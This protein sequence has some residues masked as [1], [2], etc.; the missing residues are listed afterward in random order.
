MSAFLN[1]SIQQIFRTV[2]KMFQSAR[3]SSSIGRTL[4]PQIN[5]QEFEEIRKSKSAAIFDVREPNE[6]QDVGSI[7][8][9][10]ANI[11]TSE[12]ATAFDLKPED[13]KTRYGIEK[14]EEN[15]PVVIFC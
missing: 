5:F 4:P 12:F 1:T 3:A 11:P 13:F 8:D 7:P 14:P 15:Q 9:I 2:P 6:L 10:S